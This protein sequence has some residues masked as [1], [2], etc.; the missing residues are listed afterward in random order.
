MDEVVS[1]VDVLGSTVLATAL[2]LVAVSFFILRVWP[3][4]TQEFLVAR[5]EQQQE[6]AKMQVRIAVAL[7]AASLA[8]VEMALSIERCTEMVVSEIST[9]DHGDEAPRTELAF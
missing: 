9:T 5:R 6:M 3:W 2:V 4:W 7:E 8:M 1:I